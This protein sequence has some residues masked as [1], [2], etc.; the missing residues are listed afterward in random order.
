MGGIR[1]CASTSA[2]KRAPSRPNAARR[3]SRSHAW[4]RAK[5]RNGAGGCAAFP[6]CGARVCCTRLS[7]WE[8]GYQDP[9][10]ILTDLPVQQAEARWY[11]LRS[12]IACGFKDGK[13]GGWN[14]QH[15]RS[16]TPERVERLWLAM[17]VATL[18][19]VGV[20][21]EREAHEPLP[22]LDQLPLNQIA[23]R[24]APRGP[25]AGPGGGQAAQG[26]A[27]TSPELVQSR[28]SPADA[29]LLAP[30]RAAFLLLACRTLAAPS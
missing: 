1:S 15:C 25:G 2:V 20:G 8:E 10:F 4:C 3:L 28:L 24:H 18:I 22:C 11:G 7:R 6:S 27:Q 30:A 21:A 16:K 29:S 13:R 9:W 5:A 12:W 19:A 23:R 14:W 17:A 26:Q